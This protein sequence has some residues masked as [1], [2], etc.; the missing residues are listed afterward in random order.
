MIGQRVG[1]N[2]P[3]CRAPHLQ[4][5][6]G[7]SRVLEHNECASQHLLATNNALTHALGPRKKWRPPQ[8]QNA[9]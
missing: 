5:H 7:Y 6:C 8:L 1:K 2:R 3:S 4:W 9:K